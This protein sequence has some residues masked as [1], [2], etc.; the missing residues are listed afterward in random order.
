MKQAK[1][2]QNQ[3]VATALGVA[4]CAVAASSSTAVAQTSELFLTEY[5]GTTVNVVQG[6]SVIRSFSRSVS[7][8][9]PGFVVQN[10]VKMLGQAGGSTGLEYD[11]NG[12]L[13]SGTYPNPGYDDC[14]DGATDGSRNWT[15]A[16]N[17]FTSNFAVLQSDG[18]WGGL[19][20]LFVPVKRSSGIT[21]DPT[22]DTLWITNNIGG[23]DAVQHFDLAGTLLGEFPAIHS[24]GGYAIALDPADGTLGIPGAFGT[25]NQL[26]QYSKT[27]TLLQTVSVPGT[28]ANIVGAEF[29]I[30]RSGPNLDIE[31]RCP[32]R[33]SFT[34][35]GAT[36]GGNVAF[37]YAFGTGSVIIPSGNPCVGTTL[38]LNGSATLAATAGAN[39]AGTAV[40]TRNVPQAACKRV[41]MQGL[42]L[43]TCNT[44]NVE[45]VQ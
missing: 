12:V 35:T 20:V 37:I 17:D 9:G 30:G 5:G 24:G 8:D 33:M 42:D 15:I 7:N 34:V 44:T 21:H 11:L 41:Y 26:F 31:G 14:Y 40:L 13:M 25:A 45:L 3:I 22:D 6:G 19:T 16:H 28:A 23:V 18:D 1:R 43:T 4:A 10:T 29:Q 32:G 27:G 36:P 2:N 39:A 38:G